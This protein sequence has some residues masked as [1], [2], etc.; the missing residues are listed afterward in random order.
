[1]KQ[2]NDTLDVMNYLYGN[3]KGLKVT[4]ELIHDLS[5]IKLNDTIV[6]KMVED[7]NNYE[8]STD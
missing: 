5:P 2:Y 4:A 8:E 1:M 7:I 3:L 6:D